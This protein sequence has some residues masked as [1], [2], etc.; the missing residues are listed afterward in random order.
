LRIKTAEI[1]IADL[2]NSEPDT[3]CARRTNMRQALSGKKLSKNSD[4][5]DYN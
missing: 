5:H 2:P 3:E 4:P 1:G